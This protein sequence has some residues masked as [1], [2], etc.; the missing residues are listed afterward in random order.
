M[1]LAGGFAATLGSLLRMV[2]YM[3]WM[4]DVLMGMFVGVRGY[5]S[6][7]LVLPPS[8]ILVLP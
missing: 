3:H 7:A 4:T 2:G 8:I 5:P 6:P 1:G